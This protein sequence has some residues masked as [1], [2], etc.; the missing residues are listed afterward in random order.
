MAGDLVAARQT[1]DRPGGH[2]H[3]GRLEMKRVLLLTTLLVACGGGGTSLRLF[4]S[5]WADDRGVS[6]EAVRTRLG[7]ALPSAAADV[8]VGVAGNA[9]KIVGYP[10]GAGATKWTFAHPLDAR[11]IVAG[12]VV[13]GLGNG[14]LFAL[15]ALKGT[16][17]WTRPVG[18]VALHGAG[19][20]GGVTAITL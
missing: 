13:V 2:R 12:S 5:D 11:P 9:D 18:R 17:L 1:I 7:G 3:L 10:L 6:M 16:K 20:G 4:S 8:V 15:D 14:E 19:D